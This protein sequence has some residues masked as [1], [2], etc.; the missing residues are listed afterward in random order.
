[1][2]ENMLPSVNN[3]RR[4]SVNEIKNPIELNPSPLTAFKKD[5]ENK[6]KDVYKFMSYAARLKYRQNKTNKLVAT[7][8]K[9]INKEKDLNK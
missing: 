4:I 9:R 1:M 2:I 7:G 6:N 5:S 8:L 3:L